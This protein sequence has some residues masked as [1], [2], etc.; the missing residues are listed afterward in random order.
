MEIEQN[1]Q[2]PFLNVFFFL[3]GKVETISTTVYRKETNTA[4]EYSRHYSG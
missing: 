3:M 4:N 2:I 1:N